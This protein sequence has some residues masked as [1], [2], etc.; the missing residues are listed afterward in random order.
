VSL[1]S[2]YRTVRICS[3]AAQ[4]ANVST[5]HVKVEAIFDNVNVDRVMKISETFLATELPW[6][7]IHNTSKL[8]NGPNKLDYLSLVSPSRL[9]KSNGL[10]YLA[11]L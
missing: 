7:C 8:K 6:S 2:F 10:A 11:N 9:V 4:G 1:G 5:A 3:H